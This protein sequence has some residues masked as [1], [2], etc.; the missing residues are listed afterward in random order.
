VVVD[1][2]AGDLFSAVGAGVL[3]HGRRIVGLELDGKSQ[4]FVVVGAVERPHHQLVG[5]V[6]DP[7]SDLTVSQGVP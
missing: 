7:G 3:G 2:Q 5:P 4:L 1:D 6:G